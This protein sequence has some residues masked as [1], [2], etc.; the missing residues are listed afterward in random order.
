MEPPRRTVLEYWSRKLRE[1]SE[2]AR[3]WDR[4]PLVKRYS[5]RSITSGRYPTW[6]DY[7]LG[8]FLA[9]KT[10]VRRM[11]SIG[12]GTGTLERELA[13]R[14]AFQHCDAWDIVPEALTIAAERARREGFD[15]IHY[16]VRDANQAAIESGAYDAVWFLDSLHHLHALEHICRQVATGLAP[17]GLVFLNEYIGPTSFAFPARQRELIRA[18]FTLIPLRFRKASQ[19]NQSAALAVGLPLPEE[20]AAEDASEAVRSAE[21]PRVLAGEFE[22]L[23]ARPAGG[24]LLQFLLHQTAFE[25]DDAAGERVLSML[26]GLE[27]SLM[28]VGEIGSDFAVIVARPRRQ[29]SSSQ[30][31]AAEL[32]ALQRG[33]TGGSALTLEEEVAQRRL[34]LTELEGYTAHLEGELAKRADHVTELEGYIAQLEGELARR[35]DHVTELE[36]Y[37]SQ[38][39]EELAQRA[40]RLDQAQQHVGRLE[41]RLVEEAALRRP[42]VIAVAVHQRGKDLLTR[43]LARLVASRGVEL[44]VVVVANAC[45]EDLEELRTGMPSLHMVES[46]EPLGFAEA[47]NLAVAWARD[48]LEAPEYYFFLNNDATVAPDALR[49]LVDAVEAAPHGGVA[50][51]LLLIW[52]AEDHI[53]SLGLN[54]TA[55]GQAW[56]EG[57][58]IRLGSYGPLPSRREV[59]AVTGAALLVRASTLQ[60]I[61]GWS[62]LYEY[63]FEDIDLCLRARSHGWSVVHAPDAVVTH[64]VSATSSAVTDFKRFLSWRNRFVLV[65]V[66]WPWTTLLSALPRLLGGELRELVT[67][68]RA[69]NWSDSRLQVRA[70]LGALQRLPRALAERRRRGGRKDW[71]RLLRPA[72]SVPVIRLPGTAPAAPP[73]EPPTP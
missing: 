59:L 23:A 67:R 42:G 35:T 28:Q 24:A 7:C 40:E 36:G 31:R 37:S 68:L 29:S 15:N 58:G 69:R 26:T 33:E 45:S 54:V 66:H 63:Y 53:N 27:S 49:R 14:G 32:F 6:I 9:G 47:N 71:T 22:I 12:C 2:P 11:L 19:S 57:I 17:Q 46:A 51:P 65:M 3:V 44:Q 4:H 41:R 5:E 64:A 18:A 16:Q 43:C 30:D 52:G 55:G 34:H 25:T 8:E 62:H 39:Q 60:E 72:G 13:L 1:S 73:P 48:H 70:W 21:I 56:D 10:P 38:L 20:V 61:G 50:G